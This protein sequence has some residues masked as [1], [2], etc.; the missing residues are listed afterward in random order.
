MIQKN[1]SEIL[2][3]G[4]LILAL[5]LFYLLIVKG[6]WREVEGQ[7]ERLNLKTY[8]TQVELKADESVLTASLS[9]RNEKLQHADSILRKRITGCGAIVKESRISAEGG[10]IFYTID[11]VINNA[12]LFQLL[13]TKG[14]LE[15][16]HTFEASEVLSLL[17]YADQ[18]LVTILAETNTAI[19]QQNKAKQEISAGDALFGDLIPDSLKKKAMLAQEADRLQSPLFSLLYLNTIGTGNNI[20]IGEGP[21]AG[22]SFGKDTATINRYLSHPEIQSLFPDDLQLMWS[23]SA[24]NQEKDVYA[25]YAIRHS[26]Q[27]KDAPINNQY[28][29]NAETLID[30]DRVAEVDLQMNSGGATIFE[31]MTREASSP[32]T[33][34][35]C[36]AIVLDGKVYSAPRVMET[37]LNGKIRITGVDNVIEAGNLTNMILSGELEFPFRARGISVSEKRGYRLQ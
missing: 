33:T 32:K 34:K 11:N 25:L 31:R 6:K 1:R 18:K 24:L 16:F 7:W 29:I 4:S 19:K 36:I 10:S 21:I 20:T 30:K 26:K 17:S 27:L 5:L 15:F 23:A 13:S 3:A 28:I 8:T 2:L 37:I 14:K 22:R 35:R 12:A 9:G